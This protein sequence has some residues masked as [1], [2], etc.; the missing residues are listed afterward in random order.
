VTIA[1]TSR[2]DFCRN[3]YLQHIRIPKINLRKLGLGQMCKVIEQ[4]RVALRLSAQL[5]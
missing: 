3:S 5:T 4:N 1:D 2:F